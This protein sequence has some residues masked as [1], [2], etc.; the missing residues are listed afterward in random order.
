MSSTKIAIKY[1]SNGA[2]YGVDFVQPFS[3]TTAG[4][5][6]FKALGLAGLAKLGLDSVAF[7]AAV[8]AC[9]KAF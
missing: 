2:P 5:I 1:T 8:Y 6:G 9:S 3:Q 4:A 7:G